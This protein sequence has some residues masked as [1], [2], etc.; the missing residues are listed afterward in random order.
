MSAKPWVMALCALLTLLAVSAADAAC[1]GNVCST[2]GES[3]AA[4][5]ATL[6]QAD[7]NHTNITYNCVVGH[8]TV[9]SWN[10]ALQ[11][12]VEDARMTLGIPAGIYEFYWCRV[13]CEADKTVGDNNTQWPFA[14]PGSEECDNGCYYQFHQAPGLTSLCFTSTSQCMSQG[15]YQATG[16]KCYSKDFTDPVVPPV[17]P[18]KPCGGGSCWDPEHGFCAVTESGEQ[19][20]TGDD[21]QPGKCVVGAT[22]AMCL[23]DST[24]PPPSPPD[25]PI[26]PGQP[27]DHSDTATG[28][29]SDG[30]G[31][32]TTN[33]TTINNYNG[34]DTATPSSPVDGSVGA[35]GVGGS[36]NNDGSGNSGEKG[37]DDNGKCPDGSVPTASGC[38]ATFSDSG[39]DALAQ[40]AGDA[41]LA[42]IAK[43]SQQQ[44]CEELR[45][46]NY[47][48][49]PPSD[50]TM[51][52]PFASG[53]DP[54]GADVSKSED[55][56]D[57]SKLDSSGFGYGGTCPAEDL[58]VDVGS[59]TFVVPFSKACQ[60]GDLLRAFILAFAYLGAAKIIAGVK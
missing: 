51:F 54:T 21:P 17:A 16:T 49:N 50:S 34:S 19:F 12:Y 30:A 23:G 56:G 58:T 3:A 57:T 31:G 29:T 41:L 40:A 28:T 47:L 7:P 59:A 10:A 22:G 15:Y 9:G 11:C 2:Q 26:P 14:A 33:N 35:G 6:D 8:I 37:T 1:S 39:C 55:L 4:C 38:A 36:S 45:M 46:N 20:C 25:P 13:T 44:R 18:P 48:K 27:P 5:Q 43:E 32:T 24:T 42:A 53:Q 60:W 52:D